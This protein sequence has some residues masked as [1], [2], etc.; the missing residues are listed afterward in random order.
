MYVINTKWI[1][2]IKKDKPTHLNKCEISREMS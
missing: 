2:Y 1:C